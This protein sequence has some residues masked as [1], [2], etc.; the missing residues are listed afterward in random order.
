MVQE[1]QTKKEIKA[2]PK[3]LE[4]EII[5]EAGKNTLHTRIYHVGV[6]SIDGD[7]DDCPIPFLNPL[8]KLRKGSRSQSSVPDGR[9]T[10]ILARV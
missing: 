7:E 4:L 3:Q 10:S 8:T 2:Q 5:T 1:G 6:V 9:A